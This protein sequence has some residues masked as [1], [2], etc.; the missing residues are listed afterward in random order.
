MILKSSLCNCIHPPEMEINHLKTVYGCLC[1][2][3]IIKWSHM[4]SS[5]PM[6]CI[7]QC[8]LTG[9]LPRVLSWGTLQRLSPNAD[10]KLLED[11][12]MCACLLVNYHV[13]DSRRYQLT[14][15]K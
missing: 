2:R 7:C 12:C 6:G 11:L 15:K 4:Q 8:A 1:G 3:V 5:H 10:Y 14:V 13:S 9:S